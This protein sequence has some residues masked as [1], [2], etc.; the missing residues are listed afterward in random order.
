M[1]Q[2]FCVE[3]H[4]KKLMMNI[5]ATKDTRFVAIQERKRCHCI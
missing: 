4:M 2:I 5:N 1:I 3:E